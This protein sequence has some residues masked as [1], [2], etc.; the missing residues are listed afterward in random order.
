M[1]GD[2]DHGTI[3]RLVRAAAERHGDR[4]AVVDGE[5]ELG[6]RALAAAALDAARGLMAIG[7]AAGDR[8]AIWAP[9]S[10]EWIV[11]ALAVHHAG[12][13]LVPINTR[14]KGA[15]AA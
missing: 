3:P 6:Y 5:V 10:W 4:P 11:G 12:A 1:R 8:V 7:V 9:N 14:F 15:E 13:A 2:L